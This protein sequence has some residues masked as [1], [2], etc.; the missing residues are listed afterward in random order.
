ML[1][2][3]QDPCQWQIKINQSWFQEDDGSLV[4]ANW[5]FTRCR[6]CRPRLRGKS[7][8]NAHKDSLQVVDGRL[9]LISCKQNYL[10]PSALRGV[11]HEKELQDYSN[12]ALKSSSVTAVLPSRIAIRPSVNGVYQWIFIGGIL[13]SMSELQGR[14]I[15][16]FWYSP[17]VILTR[18]PALG[19]PLLI[20]TVFVAIVWEVSKRGGSRRKVCHCRRD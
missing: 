11:R 1:R 13:R 7:L 20:T 14:M 19:L 16:A 6:P 8:S 9:A 12:V 10:Q 3:W 5:V 17:L 15:Q 2:P 4:L 18:T